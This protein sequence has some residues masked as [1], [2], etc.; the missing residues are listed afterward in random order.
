MKKILF[1]ALATGILMI[2]INGSANALPTTLIAQGSTWQYS[3]LTYDLYPSWSSADYDS[4]GWDNPGI[5][6]QT[7]DAAFG[8]PYSLPYNT[9]WA[10]YTDLALKQT[11]NIDGVLA[12]PITLN[13]ASDNGFMVFINGQ[14]VAK[15]M[16]E[17]YTGYWE[18]T[19]PLT[20]LAFI[21]PGENLIQVLAEDHG[22]ATFFDLQLS[23]DVTAVP[24]PATMLLFGTGIAVLAGRRLRK[25]GAKN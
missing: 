24:E 1:A 25:S 19:L 6:W 11:F 3:V 7:G 14:M 2:G 20:T 22:G 10:A 15:E 13:V 18:Y 4:F 23:A 12:E 17:G 8:N 21:S 9:Y 5:A 16:A